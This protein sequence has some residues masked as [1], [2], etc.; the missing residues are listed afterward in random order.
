MQLLV[1]FFL[2]KKFKLIHITC[3]FYV[4]V[5]KLSKSWELEGFSVISGQYRHSIDDKGRVSVPV[6]FREELGSSLMITR[7]PDEHCLHVYAMS[8]W[9][10]I[11]I[12]V[13]KNSAC[14]KANSYYLRTFI[15]GAIE[16]ET[17]KMGRISIPNYLREYAELGKDM[18]FLGLIDKVEI[19]DC[20]VYSDYLINGRPDV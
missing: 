1:W 16:V 9:Q 11:L 17:D 14:G 18:I 7:A 10:E 3:I 20:K 13:K 4:E 19:W 5:V 12:N 8:T 6:K 2:L 15:G